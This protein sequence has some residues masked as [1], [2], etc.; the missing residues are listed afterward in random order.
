MI[1]SKSTEVGA[2]MKV[3]IEK[4][5][6][7]ETDYGSTH[8]RW[9]NSVTFTGE[10]LPMRVL[11]SL[12]DVGKSADVIGRIAYQELADGQAQV[13]IRYWE[14]MEFEGESITQ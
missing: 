10:L 5:V 4:H 1:T 3:K 6:R 14:G 11:A 2:R 12:I 7:G 8:M 9:M 13:E